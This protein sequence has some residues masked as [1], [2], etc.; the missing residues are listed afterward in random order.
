MNETS[1]ICPNC[2]KEYL[3]QYGITTETS[4][5]HDAVKEPPKEDTVYELTRYIG[6]GVWDTF[7]GWFKNGKWIVALG[8][9][10]PDYYREYNDTLPEQPSESRNEPD[11]YEDVQKLIKTGWE[12]LDELHKH[13]EWD[14]FE[15]FACSIGNIQNKYPKKISSLPPERSGE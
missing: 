6:A 13:E 11:I 2:G 9:K 12:M 1:V 10:Q 3:M 7:H 4:V 5:W 8:H 14:E 15:K